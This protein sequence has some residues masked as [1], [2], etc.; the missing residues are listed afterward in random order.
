MAASQIQVCNLV[1]EKKVSLLI[2]QNG[3][4]RL[5]RRNNGNKP[6]IPRQYL[7]MIHGIEDAANKIAD[8]EPDLALKMQN[9]AT[10]QWNWFFEW[11]KPENGYQGSD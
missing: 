11:V 4:E 8:N 6:Q 9:F 3:V 10:Q 1:L 2:R 5:D 7:S